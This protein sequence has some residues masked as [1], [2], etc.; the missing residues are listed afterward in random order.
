MSIIKS[1]MNL[2]D[3]LREVLRGKYVFLFGQYGHGITT[4]GNR[5]IGQR[6]LILNEDIDICFLNTHRTAIID[7][8][9]I[10][11][12]ANRTIFHR[13]FI[14]S[15]ESP[16][17]EKNLRFK[18]PIHVLAMVTRFDERN[19]P[20]F[21][22]VAQNFVRLF[23]RSGTFSL[24]IIFIERNGTLGNIQ[25]QRLVE[26]SD[27]YK[28]LMRVKNG[29]DHYRIVRVENERNN[30]PYCRWDNLTKAYPDIQAQ[31]TDLR[32]AINQVQRPYS[33]DH[34]DFAIQ[35]IRNECDH[36]ENRA[37]PQPRPQLQPQQQQQQQQPQLQ[38]QQ[39]PQLQPAGVLPIVNNYLPIVFAFG[40]SIVIAIL[41]KNGNINQNINQNI[42][43][44]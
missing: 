14:R 19:Q 1:T 22:E 18:L 34:M 6:L 12:N 2:Q 5:F 17:F 30:I 10:L 35:L 43:K 11:N 32:V 16:V 25:F 4:T 13:A 28:Y 24:M 21:L 7:S 41:F 15:T 23:G 8:P 27:G 38:K 42:K 33:G 20:N 9:G 44:E 40:F 3:E 36:L 39:K 37:N 26:S 29:D 31:I